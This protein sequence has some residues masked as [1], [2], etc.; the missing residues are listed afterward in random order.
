MLQGVADPKRAKKITMVKEVKV[1]GD[2]ERQRKN[3]DRSVEA[4]KDKGVCLARLPIPH[5][6]MDYLAVEQAAFTGQ[7]LAP[8]GS[9][10]HRADTQL[11]L[12]RIAWAG[13]SIRRVLGPEHVAGASGNSLSVAAIA[14][15]LATGRG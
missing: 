1:S 3:N 5:L 11:G 2:N 4:N 15:L 6:T 13:V 9:T 7:T 8:R 14:L 12:E 10:R